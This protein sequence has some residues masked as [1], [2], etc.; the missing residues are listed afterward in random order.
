MDRV[1]LTSLQPKA[2]AYLGLHLPLWVTP[3]CLDCSSN[4][5]LNH[6]LTGKGASAA[7]SL[8]LRHCGPGV[9]IAARGAQSFPFSAH[10]VLTPLARRA[11]DQKKT[12]QPYFEGM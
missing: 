10:A 4:H 2:Q 7:C 9:P 12:I 3:A 11:T 8:Q 6:A 1:N 5:C